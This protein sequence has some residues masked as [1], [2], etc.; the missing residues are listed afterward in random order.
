MVRKKLEPSAKTPKTEHAKKRRYERHRFD[1]RMEVTVFREGETTHLWGRT[2]E[3]AED[4]VGATITG[5]LKSGEVVS[6]E[7]PIPIPPLMMKL[8]AIVR[9]SDGLRCGFEFLVVT[10][11]QRE[12]MRQLCDSLAMAS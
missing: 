8:R 5:E 10:A 9:Y 6:V 4:G 1:V 11:Q 12:T 2:N 7:F 3:I